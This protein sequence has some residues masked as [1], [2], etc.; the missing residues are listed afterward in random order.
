MLSDPF[1]AKVKA[2]VTSSARF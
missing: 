1:D 2:K